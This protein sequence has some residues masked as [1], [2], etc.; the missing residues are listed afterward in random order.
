MLVHSFFQMETIGDR[1]DAESKKGPRGDS[2]QALGQT[3]VLNFFSKLRRHASLEGAGPYFR[4]W[5]FDTS[6]RAASLDDKGL[7]TY[8]KYTF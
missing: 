7:A 6:H 1:V 8:F 2:N 4:R 3:S 5:K